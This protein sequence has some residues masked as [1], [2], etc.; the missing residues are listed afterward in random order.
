[1]AQVVERIEA[2]YDVQETEFG[3]VYRWR[4]GCV[5]VECDC[6]ERPALTASAIICGEC[7]ADH[8]NIV[9]KELEVSRPTEDAVVHPWRSLHYVEGTG[10]P[11]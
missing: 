10:I 1:M 2:H 11:F 3:K 9:Q 4:P 7:G 5:V 6:G 8:A